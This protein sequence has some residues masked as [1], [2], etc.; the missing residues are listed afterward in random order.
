MIPHVIILSLLRRQFV[1]LGQ[2][3]LLRLVMIR[4]VC[5]F[6]PSLF[7]VSS[8]CFRCL[9]FLILP[10]R[11]VP[12]RVCS[13]HRVWLQRPWAP[14]ALLCVPF[15]AVGLVVSVMLL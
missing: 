1:A 9:T 4:E 7:A 2:S 11:L 8:K 10:F 3:S 5:S 14:F 15:P 12:F 6:L 13:D